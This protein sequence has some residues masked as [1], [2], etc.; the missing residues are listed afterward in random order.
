[1]TINKIDQIISAPAQP[2]SKIK[3]S[4]EKKL[5]ISLAE[6]AAGV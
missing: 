5:M 6:I 3:Q 2:V 1:M 4:R